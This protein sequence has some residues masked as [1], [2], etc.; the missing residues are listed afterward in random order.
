MEKRKGILVID[1][2][3]I[4]NE[5]VIRFTEQLIIQSEDFMDGYKIENKNLIIEIYVKREIK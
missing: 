5:D 2:P 1:L 4:S 3:N